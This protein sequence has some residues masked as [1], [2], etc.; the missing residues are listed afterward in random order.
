MSKKRPSPKEVNPYEVQKHLFPKKKRK[1]PKDVNP[2]ETQKTH[3][4]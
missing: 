4:A 3:K 2:Y 1:N